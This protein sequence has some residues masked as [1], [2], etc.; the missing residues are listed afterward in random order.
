MFRTE[1][2][3]Y[4]DTAIYFRR[5]ELLIEYASLRNPSVCPTGV[6]VMPA[7]DD[8]NIWYGVIFIH[9]GFYKGAVLKYRLDIPLS[10]PASAPSVTFITDTFHPL[11][12]QKGRFA[13]EAKFS[14][15][16]AQ[17]DHIVDLL[18]FL[19]AS[20]KANVLDS[21]A[22]ESCLNNQAYRMY[23]NEPQ[24]FARLSEQCAKVSFADSVAFDDYPEGN[25][26]CFKPFSEAK[27]EEVFSQVRETAEA[28]GLSTN[29]NMSTLE[30]V[31]S[32]IKKPV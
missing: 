31:V 29:R 20:F 21:L 4:D 1:I 18:R 15:W 19:K 6:Y 26:I 30:G 22:E 16:V 3:N 11:V 2:S 14:N 27:F 9:K 5:Y 24:L 12:D 17:R 25:T 8:I 10:Y 23:H 7:L 32:K 13:V 28:T